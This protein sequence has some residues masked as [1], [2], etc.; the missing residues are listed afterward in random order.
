MGLDERAHRLLERSRRIDPVRVEDIDIV[1]AHAPQALVETREQIFARAAVAIGTW[2]HVVTGL[3]RDDQL[4]AKGAEVLGHPAAEILFRR[5]V[6]RSVVVGEIEVG[7]AEIEGAP[8]HRAAGLEIVDAAEIVPQ[9]ER[10]G[11]KVEPAPSAAPVGHAAV[12]ALR[13]GTILVGRHPRSPVPWRDGAWANADAMAS[14][15]SFGR[16]SRS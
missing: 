3:R 15:S 10:H 4:V 11:G 13:V 9:A 1:E 7:D 14:L 2:P 8:E 6:G 16:K 12:I 5:T